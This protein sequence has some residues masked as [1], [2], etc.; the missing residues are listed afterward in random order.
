[1][2]NVR[3]FLYGIYGGESLYSSICAARNALSSVVSITGYERLS[4]HP[5]V[6]R[7]FEGIFNS[8]S[9]NPLLPKYFNI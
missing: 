5:L 3:S 1:M 4:H 7:F 6:S 9:R 2:I 8:F